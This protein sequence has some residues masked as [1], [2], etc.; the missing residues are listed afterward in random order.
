[1]LLTPEIFDVIDNLEPG[2][3]GEYQLTDAMKKVARESGIYALEFEGDRYDMG[4]KLGFLMAN[5]RRGLEH[6]ETA[7][8]FREYLKSLSKTL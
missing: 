2:A 5:V 7:D 1:V 4:S 3:G 8:A 6:P